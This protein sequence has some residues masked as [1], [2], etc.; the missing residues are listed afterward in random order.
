M[1]AGMH[2]QHT[3]PTRPLALAGA[4]RLAA[5]GAALL[6]LTA[7]GGPKPRPALPPPSVAA[8]VAEVSLKPMASA[9][10]AV[11]SAEAPPDDADKAAQA[12]QA[13]V[14][15]G[16]NSPPADLAAV[17]AGRTPP[18]EAVYRPVAVG[19]LPLALPVLVE[20]AGAHGAAVGAART[21]RLVR[22]SGVAD[23]EGRLLASTALSAALLATGAD[24]VMDLSTWRAFSRAELAADL[25]RKDWLADQ[26]VPAVSQ[27]D[28]G[29]LSLQTRGMG[30]FG[31]P[32]LAQS[33]VPVAEARAAFTAFQTRVNALRE[34]GAGS[35]LAR[36]AL[37]W[38][39]CAEV[40]GAADGVCRVPPSGA[41]N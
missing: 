17:M 39:A 33:G 8:A 26:V 11:F 20:A 3:S 19:E 40:T 32:D 23:G 27:A 37:A 5:L 30:R 28:D 4:V 2:A 21:A 31:L 29:S 12:L 14:V 41:K 6:G 10:F 16:F 34:A 24:V 36:E 15:A 18:A 7:C 9:T 25:A 1:V 35:P 13:A 38:P 22:S